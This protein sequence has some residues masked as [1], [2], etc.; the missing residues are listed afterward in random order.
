MILVWL[1]EDAKPF[2]GVTMLDCTHCSASWVKSSFVIS[3][4]CLVSFWRQINIKISWH[5]S[6]MYS[7]FIIIII[8]L[9]RDS[10]GGWRNRSYDQRIVRHKNSTHGSRRWWRHYLYGERWID[11]SPYQ[12][13][14][15]LI[16]I[17]YF[18]VKLL[19]E[20]QQ[21]WWVYIILI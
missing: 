2:C 5:L 20:I 9:R 16:K 7:I 13:K 6:T 11:N 4:S 15:L 12:V 8:W 19:I 21:L 1:E 17:L 18:T 10:G 14:C 3:Q